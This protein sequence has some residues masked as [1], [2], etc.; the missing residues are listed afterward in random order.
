[1]DKSR[2]DSSY[3]SVNAVAKLFGVESRLI[4]KEIA[5]KRLPA[6]KLGDPTSRRPVIRIPREALQHWEFEQLER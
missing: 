5:Q 1:M 6:I 4:Y 2:E 3:L